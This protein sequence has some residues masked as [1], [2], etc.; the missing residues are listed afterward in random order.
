MREG[1]EGGAGCAVA[2]GSGLEA[3]VRFGVCAV[4]V[5]FHLLELEDVPA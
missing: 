4:E 3:G 1:V 5:D 2:V